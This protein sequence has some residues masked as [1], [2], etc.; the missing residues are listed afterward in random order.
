MQA[1]LG[2]LLCGVAGPV[3]Y[4]QVQAAGH[5]RGALD[6]DTGAA[7]AKLVD[8]QLQLDLPVAIYNDSPRAILGLELWVEA[9]ACPQ[10][11]STRAECT[12]V[13]SF[14]QSEPTRVMPG[15]AA[16]IARSI[17]T[18]LPSARAGDVMQVSRRLTR[19][20]DDQ[21]ALNRARDAR[22]VGM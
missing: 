15:S 20:E 17:T 22:F 10:Q 18:P 3:A 4:Q 7:S 16:R 8:G 13:A 9:Y 2:L 1:V 21:D 6:I 11:R 5:T 12:K 14:E 19:I